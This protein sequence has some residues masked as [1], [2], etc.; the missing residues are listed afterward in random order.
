MEMCRFHAMAGVLSQVPHG[1]YFV[2]N[3][4]GTIVPHVTKMTSELSLPFHGDFTMSGGARKITVAKHFGI[5]FC[6]TATDLPLCF[7][8]CVPIVDDPD[9]ATLQVQVSEQNE[10]GIGSNKG[11][12][13]VPSLSALDSQ[14]GK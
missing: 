2:N 1:V 3:P 9:E 10:A 5:V 11:V 7:A 6:I 14:I 8:W 13:V 12:M 4:D